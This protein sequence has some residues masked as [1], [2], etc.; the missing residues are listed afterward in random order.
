MPPTTTLTIDLLDSQ[1]R[2]LLADVA[3]GT[4][5]AELDPIQHPALRLRATFSATVPGQSAA[6]DEWQLSWQT[7]QPQSYYLYLPEIR[8]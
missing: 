1:G 5:L 2:L 3:S 6:L 4:S 8:R 7:V